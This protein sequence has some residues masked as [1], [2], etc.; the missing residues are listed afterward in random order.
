MAITIGFVS[1]MLRGEKNAEGGRIAKCIDAMNC[2][3]VNLT[4]K[5]TQT[6]AINRE[7]ERRQSSHE[8]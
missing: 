5:D 7:L 6:V 1:R 8:P 4:E 2:K 3:V